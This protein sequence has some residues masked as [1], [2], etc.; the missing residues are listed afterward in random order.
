MKFLL[1]KRK[2]VTDRK[3]IH[4]ILWDGRNW[5]SVE[6]IKRTFDTYEIKM[7]ERAIANIER[8]IFPFVYNL[9]SL[10]QPPATF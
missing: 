7:S 1:R 6:D 2:N 10:H 8:Y 3:I 5:K 9:Q 4:K